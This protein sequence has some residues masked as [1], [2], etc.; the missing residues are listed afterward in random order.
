MKK[1]INRVSYITFRISKGRVIARRCDN[2]LVSTPPPVCE[3]IR[4][5]LE[6]RHTQELN[7]R[8]WARRYLRQM[9]S[10]EKK[11]HNTP[12]LRAHIKPS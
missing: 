4:Q 10:D 12:T 5:R 11:S 6:R 7:D 8:H 2:I 3:R 9:F 1:T